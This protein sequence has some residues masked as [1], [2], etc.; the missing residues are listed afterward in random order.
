[1]I[2]FEITSTKDI[3]SKKVKLLGFGLPKVGKT[4][5]V[6]TIPREKD[7][8]ILYIPVDPGYMILRD[9]EFH[10]FKPENNV[11]SIAALEYLVEYVK[12][13]ALAGTYK[14]CIIDGLDDIA[15]AVLNERKTK[16]SNLMKAYGEMADF[17]DAWIKT[18]R[19]IDGINTLFITHMVT[20]E[21][22][23]GAATKYY[24][25]VPGKKLLYEL[26]KYF[27]IIFCMRFVETEEG[28]KRMLQ[29]SPEA[30]VKYV[31]GDRSGSLL[32]LEPPDLGYIL[33]KIET[34]MPGSTRPE[35]DRANAI[36]AELKIRH[37]ENEHAKKIITKYLEN[38]GV[39]TPRALGIEALEELLS[40]T[41]R[42]A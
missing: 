37:S 17:C 40:K 21:D 3:A 31:T 38:K 7:S 11:W 30:D 39:K 16:T 41:E 10:V 33:N 2:K 4:S 29:T 8:D 28:V 25:A 20:K 6:K 14:W 18:M 1:M 24:P 35:I 12:K 32:P 23:S 36:L 26:D 13:A 22:E 34:S 19:D 27:D 5:L 42:S 9:N 15:T